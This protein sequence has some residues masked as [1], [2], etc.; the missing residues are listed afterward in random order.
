MV[1]LA[2]EHDGKDSIVAVDA[3]TGKDRWRAPRKSGG[4]YAT[5]CVFRP[6][7]RPAELIA[8]SYEDGIT[9]L[10]PATGKPNWEVNAFDK[11]HVEASIASPIVHG[12]LILGTSGWLSVRYESVALRPRQAKGK[13]DT[14]YK[15]DRDPPLVPTPVAKGDLLFLWNDRGIVSCWDAK[16]GANHWRERV[17]GSFYASPVIAGSHLYC[18]SREGDMVVLSAGKQFEEV[19][20]IAL[21]EGTHATPAIA[22]GRMFVRT[23]GRVMCLEAKGER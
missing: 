1:I 12:D 2:C 9:S 17:D 18:P 15:L 6:P 5:P 3:V 11:R 7:G 23:F 20:H 19:A 14:L 13:I 16:T 8:V 22:G 10:D 21:G 4:T